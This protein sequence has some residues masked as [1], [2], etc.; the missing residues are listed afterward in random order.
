MNTPEFNQDQSKCV[1][2]NAGREIIA[3]GKYLG[4][5]EMVKDCFWG[6]HMYH[7]SYYL[8]LNNEP[9]K[10]WLVDKETIELYC[11]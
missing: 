10:V 1:S 4:S 9:D 2:E 6:G 5:S 7:D 8:S 11:K 3:N